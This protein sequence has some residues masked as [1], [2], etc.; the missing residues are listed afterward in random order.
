MLIALPEIDGVTNPTLFAGRHGADGCNGCARRCRA[1]SALAL[2]SRAMAP[3]PERIEALADKVLRLAHLR[4]AANADRRVGIVL[5]GFPPNAGAAG[6]AA[7]MSVFESLFNMLGAMKAAD[8][9][10]TP[11]ETLKDLRQAVL[12]GNAAQYGQPA[13]VAA[14]VSAAKIVA[15]SR[16]RGDVE[17]AW[18][19]APGRHQTD[20]RGVH[21][22]GCQFGNVFVGL[23]PTFGDEGDPMRRLFEKGFAPTHAFV[24]FYR[25]LKD[26]FGADALLH[27][28]RHGGLEFMPGK[29]AVVGEGCWPDRL[30]GNLPNI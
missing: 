26:G 10:L 13:N 30:I 1:P 15:R 5:H 7:Y 9:D 6:I 8:Y 3:C 24:T 29:Q 20:G 14:T 16:W 19:P 17:R 22:L 25:W 2:T 18:R 11:P 4:R 28:G 23:P 21:L 27:F 12:Q